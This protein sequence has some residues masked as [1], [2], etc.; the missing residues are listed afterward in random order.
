MV[1]FDISCASDCA[2]TSASCAFSVNLF[3]LNAIA[4][5]LQVVILGCQRMLRKRINGYDSL[6]PFIR[7]LS[8]DAF[9]LF[10]SA[11]FQ[12][13]FRRKYALPFQARSPKVDEQRNVT[14]TPRKIINYL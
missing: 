10:L 14:I 4:I 3:M 6:Y 8:V 1:L 13:L 12:Y 2:P 9:A 11:M 5:F 7:F